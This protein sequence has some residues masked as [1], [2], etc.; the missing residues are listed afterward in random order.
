[1]I[2]VPNPNPG[3]DGEATMYV[4]RPWTADDVRRAVEG[5]PHP[6]V[7]VLDFVAGVNGLIESYR[8]NGMEVERALRQ[9]LAQIGV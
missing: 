9:I 8:L 3:D 4:F 6:R 2:Q 1:M 7:K 5:I